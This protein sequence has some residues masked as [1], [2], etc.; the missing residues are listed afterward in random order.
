MDEQA[1]R[2]RQLMESA[3]VNVVYESAPEATHMMHQSDPR[4]YTSLLR[5]WA[6]TAIRE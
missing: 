3:G 1:T 6:G 5:D 2:A 4:R